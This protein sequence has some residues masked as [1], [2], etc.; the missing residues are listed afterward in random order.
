MITVQNVIDRVRLVTGDKTAA[1]FQ[2][3]DIIRWI[4]DAQAR[5]LKNT[6]TAQLDYSGVST[7]GV[8]AYPVANG[9]LM[10]RDVWYD[11]HKL[12]RVTRE[13]LN[14]LNPFWMQNPT[15]NIGTPDLYWIQKDTINLYVTPDTT[16]KAITVTIVPRPTLLVAT[17]DQLVVPD[18]MLESIVALCLENAKQWDEDWTGAAYFRDNAKQRLGEDAYVESMRG[19]ESYPAIRLAPGENW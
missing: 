9:F 1:V 8:F 16:G 13:E 17:T 15:T 5:A 11:G 14:Q 10:V 19:T 4:N 3:V 6:E 18:E 12:R 7:Q 2:D